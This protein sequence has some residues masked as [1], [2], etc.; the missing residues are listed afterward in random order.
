MSGALACLLL[1]AVGGWPSC[2]RREAPARDRRHCGRRGLGRR[3]SPDNGVV[4]LV[5]APGIARVV[6]FSL[7][8][9]PN[10]FRLDDGLIGQTQNRDME[11]T[12]Q[13]KDFGGAKLW[14]APQS[15][16]GNRWGNWPPRY[17]LDSA[18]CRLERADGSI[19]LYGQPG[20]AAGVAFTRT[21][22]LQGL[23]AE[24]EVVMTNVSQ[25]PVAWGIWTVACVKPGGTVF[26][27]WENARRSGRPTRI[28]RPRRIAAGNGLRTRSC[29]SRPPGRE[30]SK[31]FSKAKAG[32]I[33][34]VNEGQALF[35]TFHAEAAAPYPAGEGF[36]EVYCCKKFV[37]L[38]HV[39]RLE[40][41]KP[42]D[43]C[44]V[45]RTLAS[46]AGP[47]GQFH[48]GGKGRLDVGQGGD[49]ALTPCLDC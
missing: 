47:A 17:G 34:S 41:L 38:E 30:G 35:I 4:E 3:A 18:P 29:L 45:E 23:A 40:S 19:I 31:L 2:R 44:R 46:V 25:R 20:G 7:K 9:K 42:G 24:V 16:W 6:H 14:V 1:A 10:V 5:A 21:I 26:L 27:P 15:Q 11:A 13:Y 39:G 22:S 33:G 49:A 8:G 32:W 48:R 37:E 43:T 12:G 36:A 28:I